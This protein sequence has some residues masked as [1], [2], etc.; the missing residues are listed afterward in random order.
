M[1]KRTPVN[2]S[3]WSLQY[4][5]NQGEVF[6]GVTRHLICAG[7]V[8]IDADGGIQ[9]VGD[10]PGQMRMALDNVEAVLNGAGMGFDNVVHL[11][12]YTT[13]IDGVI[14][15]WA[16]FAD[17]MAEANVMPPQSLI[18]VARLAFPEL[19]IEIEARAAA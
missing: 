9:H 2:P 18:G 16:V 13:D 11:T 10:L 3:D 7:Q 12:I 17:R 5:F 19:L 4:S 1:L 6:E 15:N 8:A 14:E